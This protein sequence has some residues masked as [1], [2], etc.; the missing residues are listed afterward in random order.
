MSSLAKR[1]EVRVLPSKRICMELKSAAFKAD[2]QK[3]KA[4]SQANQEKG[5]LPLF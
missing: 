4:L 5:D 1:P 2:D 3:E